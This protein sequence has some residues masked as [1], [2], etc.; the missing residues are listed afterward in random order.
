MYKNRKRSMKKSDFYY[1]VIFTSTKKIDS[2]AYTLMSEKMLNLSQQQQGF[3]GLDSVRD[4]NGKG[5]TVSYWQTLDDI[6]NWKANSQHQI[7]QKLG[8]ENWYS[9]YSVRIC[10]VEHEYSS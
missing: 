3:L 6:K 5:I 10:K 8:Q 4:M 1:A 9:E 2:E 7:A